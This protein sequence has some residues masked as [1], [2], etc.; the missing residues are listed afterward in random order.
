MVTQNGD[1]MRIDIDDNG[2]IRM[3]NS[4]IWMWSS[5][6][7]KHCGND[8]SKEEHSAGIRSIPNKAVMEALDGLPAVKVHFVLYLQKKQFTQH[9][10]IMLRKMVSRSKL[11][12]AQ[13]ADI[14]EGEEE[15][16]Y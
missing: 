3:L 9:Y 6:C 1:I 16:E 2:I 11:E 12:K 4:D 15:E 5:R 13:R 7:N 14:S 8:L 10:R